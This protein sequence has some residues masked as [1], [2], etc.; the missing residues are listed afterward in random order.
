MNNIFSTIRNKDRYLNNKLKNYRKGIISEEQLKSE[1]ER[2]FIF[3]NKITKQ[4]IIYE[5]LQYLINIVNL[6]EMFYKIE[7][8][9]HPVIRLNFGGK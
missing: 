1:C 6:W 3:C 7:F 2:F 5:D 4:N 9:Y 8:N